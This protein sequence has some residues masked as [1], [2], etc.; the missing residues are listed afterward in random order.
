MSADS[1]QVRLSGLQSKALIIG[2]IGLA[3]CVLGAFLDIRRFFISYLFGYLFWLGLALG[4]LGFLMIHHLSGGRWGFPV[5]RFFEAGIMTLPL[6]ALLF[7]PICLG[8]RD[9]YPWTDPHA[10][11]GSSVLQHRA[12]YMNTP[13]FIIR[14]AIFFSLWSIAAVALNKWSFDQEGTTD[15]EP[16]R[17]LRTFSGPG[18]LLYPLTVTFVLVDW[19]MSLETDWYSTMFAVL[20]IIGQM[21]SG[22]AF[23]IILLAWLRKTEPYADVVTETHFHHLGMLLF[24]FVMLWTYM[25]FSQLL[26]IYSG[27]LPQE[28]LWYTHRIAGDWKLIMWFLVIF[29]FAIPFLLLLSRDIKKDPDKLAAIAAMVL[30]AHVADVYWMI[31]PSF[32]HTGISFNWLDIA[33]PAGVGGIW[34]AVFA[35]RLKAH[36]LLVHNDPRQ[37]LPHGK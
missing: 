28:I 17:K 2:V 16:T 18:I 27:N 15:V 19:I 13:A 34:L 14:A 5:R 20:I 30:V 6:M 4:C 33:A 22:L 25:A 21:L 8:L 32:F 26:I 10:V 23:A 24:A 35:G 31:A 11:A 36:P 7:I 1:I 37:P 29:H 3:L 12:Q 9:L